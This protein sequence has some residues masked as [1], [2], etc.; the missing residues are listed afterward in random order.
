M[1]SCAF[2][3]FSGKEHIVEMTDGRCGRATVSK[4]IRKNALQT[5]V[6][7]VNALECGGKVEQIGIVKRSVDEAFKALQR[8]ARS[9]SYESV[10]SSVHPLNQRT[11]IGQN[12]SA[13]SPCNRGY[14]KTRNFLIFFRR[15]RTG[16][17]NGVIGDETGLFVALPAVIEQGFDHRF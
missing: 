11:G 1:F 7:A 6:I 15:K 4:S 9:L 5:S 3:V 8:F 10:R 17:R 16:N 2:G 13:I 12:A 14:Q